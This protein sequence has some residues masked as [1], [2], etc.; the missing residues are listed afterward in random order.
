MRVWDVASG[1]EIQRLTGHTSSVNSVSFSGDGT[2]VASASDDQTVRVF[3]LEMKISMKV[4]SVQ[5]F[6]QH[7]SGLMMES[8]DFSGVLGLTAGQ[9][10]LI[11]QRGGRVVGDDEEDEKKYEDD[12]EDSASGG[13][14]KEP[15]LIM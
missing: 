13:S 10:R 11:E 12:V 9:K 5:V 3:T 6:G 1:D 14:G 8:A 7:S 4:I 15:C 2:R